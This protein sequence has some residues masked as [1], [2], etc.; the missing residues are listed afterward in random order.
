MNKFYL[1]P[2]TTMMAKKKDQSAE[3]LA[4]AHRLFWKTGFTKTTMEAIA[5]EMGIS[6]KTLYKHFPGKVDLL[7]AIFIELLDKMAK[8]IGAILE[9]EHLPFLVQVRSL[10]ATLSAQLSRINP[11][12]MLD[13]K[14]NLPH[15]FLQIR[16]EIISNCKSPVQNFIKKGKEEGL[17]QEDIQDE[18]GAVICMSFLKN[19]MD[20][21][22]L[23][24]F[25]KESPR[26]E[27]KLAELSQQFFLLV[28]EGVLT[29]EARE[30]M[31]GL[32]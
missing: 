11:S 4:K 22:F 9:N 27:P 24:Q 15:I 10:H 18:L 19:L 29:E 28:F 5:K 26:Q 31:K 1:Q 8:K 13:L 21:E 3:I 17:I 30:D 6:K 7:K 25:T 23:Q 32:T 14:E 2:K 20:E 16:G 12:L